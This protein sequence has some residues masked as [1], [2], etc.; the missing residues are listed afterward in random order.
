M[1]LVADTNRIIASLIKDSS[2]RQILLSPKFMFISVGFAKIEIAKYKKEILSKAKVSE[3]EFDKI[4]NSLSSNIIFLEDKII[5]SKI[6]EAKGLMDKIDPKDTPFIAAALASN[7]GVWS[8]DAHF[9]KQKRVK[10]WKTKEL[11]GMI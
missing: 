11:I 9:D 5:N 1:I 6:D 7:C 8:E 2:S 10:V 4:M 3:P